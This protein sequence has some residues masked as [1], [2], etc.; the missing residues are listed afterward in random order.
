M[1]DPAFVVTVVIALAAVVLIVIRFRRRERL[2]RIELQ[3]IQAESGHLVAAAN[4]RLAALKEKTAQASIA[5]EQLI[6]EN[7]E[8]RIE[9]EREKRLR[10]EAEVKAP[11][12]QL[13]TPA[14]GRNHVRRLTADQAAALTQTMRRFEGRPVL[15]VELRDEE[16]RLL[17]KQIVSALTDAGWHVTVHRLETLTPPQFGIICSHTPEDEASA[18]LVGTLRSFNMTVHD[19]REGDSLVIMVGLRPL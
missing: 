14:A 9:L 11:L 2:A 17:A 6:R 10:I 13:E 7:L 4:V 1:P 5:H 12:P 16:A 19:R 3:K 8:L 15:V 18:V